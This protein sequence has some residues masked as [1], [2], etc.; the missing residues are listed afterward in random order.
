MRMRGGGRAAHRLPDRYGGTR[1]AVVAAIATAAV[2]VLLIG[3]IPAYA[4]FRGTATGAAASISSGGLSATISA[5]TS[6][7]SSIGTAPTRV[8]VRAGTPGMVPGVQAQTLS[9]TIT[10]TGTARS[11]ASASVRV[12]SAAVV[13]T[14]TW[15]GIQPYLQVTATI[16]A[17][18]ATAVATSSAGI[19][20]TVTSTAA[21]QPGASV[22]VVLT[23]T[24]PASSG[25]TDLL[26]ALLPYAG[27]S[28]GVGIRSIL[29]L[30]PQ[31]TLTQVPVT[32]P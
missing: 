4:Y 31:V 23:F 2:G 22:Q 7:T 8:V 29:T 32:A 6:G 15:A 5:P 10:N 9:Y 12:V 21:I 26:V 3:G 14:T 20:G 30:Q 28:S 24:L 1:R 25:S 19:D 16:G 27:T 13:D 18:A 17:G 11:P